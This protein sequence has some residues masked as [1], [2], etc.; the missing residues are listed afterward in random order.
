[1]KAF[2]NGVWER[3]KNPENLENPENPDSNKKR[4]K[5]HEQNHLFNTPDPN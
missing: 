1:V 4:V 3:E 5:I 2:P